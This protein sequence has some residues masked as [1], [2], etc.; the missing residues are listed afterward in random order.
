M[1]KFFGIML[2]WTANETI[3][4]FIAKQTFRLCG[5]IKFTFR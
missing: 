3:I 2:R 1:L 4:V 5:Y